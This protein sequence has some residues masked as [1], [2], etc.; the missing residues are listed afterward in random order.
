MEIKDVLWQVAE[1]NLKDESFFLVDIIVKGAAGGKMK[2]LILLD[3]DEGVNIDDCADLSRAVGMRVEAEDLIE[4][5][6]I[7]E[8]SSPGLD[9]PLKLK[10]QY[11]N[12]VGRK[13]KLQLTDGKQLTGKLVEAGQQ[14]ISFEKEVKE[15]KKTVHQL[16]SIGFDEIE[17]A[18]V[19]VSFK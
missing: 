2:V 16:V 7:L 10:R 19:L 6:Y 4:Q 3:G 15:K 8:V 14:E 1:E 9:H 13:L 11:A 18:N 17:K 5:A 12:N